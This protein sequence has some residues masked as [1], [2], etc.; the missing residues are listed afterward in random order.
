[1][2]ISKTVAV[3]FAFCTWNVGA[4]SEFQDP[5]DGSVN[6]ANQTLSSHVVDLKFDD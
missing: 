4:Q 5:V 1:M 3:C 6:S 2:I